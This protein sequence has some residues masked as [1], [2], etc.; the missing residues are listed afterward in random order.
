MVGGR[1]VEFGKNMERFIQNMSA[2]NLSKLVKPTE[3]E[4]NKN[5]VSKKKTLI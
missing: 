4:K 5:D 1:G 3:P 2:L